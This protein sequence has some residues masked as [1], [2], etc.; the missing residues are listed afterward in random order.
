MRHLSTTISLFAAS[1]AGMFA[2]LACGSFTSPPSD[3]GAAI[4]GQESTHRAMLNSLAYHAIAPSYQEAATTTGALKTA[5][6]AN[7]AAVAAGAGVDEARTSVQAAWTDVVVA[8]EVVE[9]MQLGPAAPSSDGIGGADKRDEVYSWP[10]VNPC[11]IDQEIVD[12]EYLQS[13]F[14]TANLVNTYGIDALEYLLFYAGDAN[15]CAPQLPLNVDGTWDALG[16][17]VLATRRAD[18][19]VAV[20]TAVANEASALAQE[21]SA[22]DGTFTVYLAEPDKNNSPYAN[23]RNGLNEVVRAMFY[24]DLEVKDAKVAVPAGLLEC[25]A[26]PCLSELEFVFAQHSK[27]A[28]L[29]NLEG[30]KRLFHG[31]TDAALHTGF[32]DLLVSIGEAQLAGEMTASIETALTT[33]GAVEG[34][35]A[36]ALTSDTTALNACHTTIR[37][38]TNWLKGDFSTLLMLTIPSEAA[39]DAD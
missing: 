9:Q 5:T 32:D 37:A 35:F 1:I 31:G 4:P 12:Q 14:F 21:W 11:R 33:C 16:A 15:A 8:W 6:L 27:A 13:D 30:F 25:S 28:V 22:T 17:D 26:A 24:L 38:I 39:G 19:A 34:S 3:S 23:I 10:S 2:P 7:A 36:T 18:Y 29:A 20:A